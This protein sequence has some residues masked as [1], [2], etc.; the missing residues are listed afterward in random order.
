MTRPSIYTYRIDAVDSSTT[1][2]GSAPV[3][4][5]ESAATWRIIK[6]VVSGSVTS[7]KYAGGN[8]DVDSV[9]ADRASLSYS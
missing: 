5:S 3:G 8:T 7:I 1:Y 6:I 2:I 9:W 4:S